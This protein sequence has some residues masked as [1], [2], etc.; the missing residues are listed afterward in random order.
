VPYADL[1]RELGGLAAEGITA[2]EVWLRGNPHRLDLLRM[3]FVVP[4]GPGPRPA[5]QAPGTGAADGFG[6]RLDLWTG[7]IA[8]SFRLGGSPVTVRT[9][10]H[11]SLDVIAVRMESAL[12]AQGRLAVRLAF[13]YGSQSWSNAA[14][15]TRPEAH[16]TDVAISGNRC[17]V[18]RSL[19]GVPAYSATVGLSAGGAVTVTGRHGLVL[20]S[21]RNVAEITV[22][23]S[24]SASPSP[25]PGQAA[26]YQGLEAA[27]RA[28][29]AGFWSRGAAV[30]VTSSADPRA[31]ELQRRIMLSQYLTAINCAGSMPPQETGLLANSWNGKFHLEMH[32]WHAAHFALWGRPDLLERSLGWY[33]GV[34]SAAR[35]I[36]AA[37]LRARAAAHPGAGV[38]H[39]GPGTARQPRVRARLLESGSD[40]VC[41]KPLA[42]SA[43]GARLTA[44]QARACPGTLTVTF[45]YRYMP[46]NAALREVIASGAIGAITSVHFEWALD[47]VHGADY[48]RRWHREKAS[49]GGLLGAQGQPPFRPGELVDR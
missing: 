11:P 43:D 44:D 15:W 3:G 25:S 38:L 46:R 32:W 37:R 5:W 33:A 42:T 2:E 28:W 30:D 4:A 35:R 21:S 14:D 36:A 16:G 19:D 40:A 1:S 29:W 48:F 47:T 41:E 9:C 12:L 27:A 6:Q 49:S 17:M 26:A 13:P 20:S 22:R 34:L 45:N 18:S 24:R 10:C 31:G 8:S 7:V 23:L 39:G